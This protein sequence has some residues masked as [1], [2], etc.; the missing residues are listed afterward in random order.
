M[1]KSVL[2]VN[3][4]KLHP[5]SFVPVKVWV[6]LLASNKK[7]SVKR[8]DHIVIISLASILLTP[9]RWLE[10]LLFNKKIKATNVH[11]S[12]IFILGHWRSGTTLLQTLFSKDPQLGYLC[13]Y[14][15]FMPGLELLNINVL[16][17]ILDSVIPQKRDMDNMPRGLVIPEEEEFAITATSMLGSYHSLW[18]PH[19]ETYFEKYN[20]FEKIKSN[21]LRDWKE[22]Y[23][24][25]LQKI[26]LFTDKERLVLKNPPNTARI[27]VLLELFPQA[28]FVNIYRNPYDVFLSMRNMYQKSICPLFLQE[29]SDLEIDEKIFNYYERVMKKFIA[30]AD[31]IPKSNYVNIRYENL[32]QDPLTV[33][34]EIYQALDLKFDPAQVPVLN[35]LESIKNYRKNEFSID[36][37]VLDKINKRWKFA[38]DYFQYEMKTI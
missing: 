13:G 23:Y 20:L 19:N 37:K 29:M 38:F 5:L 8:L 9:V 18:F 12:P 6:K 17:K 31:L 24:K 2:E 30:E 36:P 10:W 7:L 15:A 34:K 4:S 14:Q 35:H 16:Y 1:L 28:K 3:L 32:E 27:K 21:E 25:L 33:M 22:T 11:P 26:V